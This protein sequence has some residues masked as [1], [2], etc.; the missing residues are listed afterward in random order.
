MNAIYR[1]PPAAPL[2]PENAPFSPEQRAWLN[3]F[4]AGL[5]S[6]GSQPGTILP[7]GES[8]AFTAT[9]APAAAAPEFAPR[10]GE[11]L[12]FRHVEQR[13][14]GQRHISDAQPFRHRNSS[15]AVMMERATSA[16]FLFSF[17]ATWRIRA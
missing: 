11:M 9:L 6:S 14:V 3:G 10:G 4:F 12:G 16:I 7:A 15:A 5:L 1:P 13:R 8:A 2:I 17:I